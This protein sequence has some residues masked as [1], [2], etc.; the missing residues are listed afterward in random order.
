MARFG[1]QGTRVQ[2]LARDALWNAWRRG[3]WQLCPRVGL[4]LDEGVWQARG[5][6]QGGLNGRLRGAQ[7]TYRL[8]EDGHMKVAAPRQRGVAGQEIGNVL[9]H[10]RLGCAARDH[11][12]QVARLV[13]S[14]QRLQV[15]GRGIACDRRRHLHAMHADASGFAQMERGFGRLAHHRAV[16]HIHARAKVSLQRGVTAARLQAVRHE[17]G[18]FF[19]GLDG[20]AGFGFDVE[21]LYLARKVGYRVIEIPITWSHREASRVDPV[22]DTLR[23]LADIVRVRWNDVRG[24]YRT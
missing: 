1:K 19:E 5:S 3:F 21:L 22:R 20:A 18:E 15:F 6:A 13:E 10:A 4:H 23:M 2:D 24:R 14:L 12:M 16:A 8:Q 7:R 9:P 17:A 11:L